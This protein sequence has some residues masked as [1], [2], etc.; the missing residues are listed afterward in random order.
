[1]K[2]YYNNTVKVE[3]LENG[4]EMIL[5]EGVGFY[6]KKHTL[7]HA[8]EG[9]IIDGASI[10]RFFWRAIGSPF[11]GKYRRASVMHDVYC[12]KRTYSHED[13]HKMFYDAMI[14][15]EVPEEKA[16]IMY[17]AVKTFGPKW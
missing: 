15:D 16:Q 12:V 13:V 1:M 2:P 7:W 9:S 17:Q 6:D 11:V 8:P 3:W 10:P 14:C 4:R 5:L